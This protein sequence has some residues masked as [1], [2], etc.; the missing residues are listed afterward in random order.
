MKSKLL[1]PKPSKHASAKTSIFAPSPITP[2]ETEHVQGYSS[3]VIENPGIGP[4]YDQRDSEWPQVAREIIT[5][6]KPKFVV[7]MIGNNDR[8]AI[9]E[10]P[11]PPA[12]ANAQRTQPPPPMDADAPR[13]TSGAPVSLRGG[14]LVT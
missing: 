8:Q 13:G 14:A 5:A 12:P 11:P 7:M 4:S 9:R 2:D 10:K 1:K 3:A 6:E